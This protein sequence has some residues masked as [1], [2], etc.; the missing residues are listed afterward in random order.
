MNESG[1]TGPPSLRLGSFNLFS[2]RSP[3]DGRTSPDRLLSAIATLDVDVLGVQEVDRFQPRSG[4]VDQVELVAK[5]MAT[6]DFRFAETVRGR[7]D[8]PGWTAGRALDPD[9]LA[10]AGP[11]YGIALCSRVPVSQWHELRLPPPARPY[12]TLAISETGRRRLRF[13]L[14]R[15]PRAAL[16]AVLT[17]PQVTVVVTHLSYVPPGNVGQLLRVVRWLRTLPPPTVLLGDLNLPLWAARALTL[18]TPLVEAPTFPASAPRVQLDHILAAGFPART[19]GTGSALEL[20][21]SDHRAVRAE[22]TR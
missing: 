17:E 14:D 4:S 13:E 3:A 1:R 5:A 6:S 15:Q 19:T 9:G 22:L 16:A 12:P 11:G 7:M 8:A 21:V 18:R 2:G 10:P 20:A